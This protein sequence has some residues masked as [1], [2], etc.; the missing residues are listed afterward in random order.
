MR[1]VNM[2]SL[3]DVAYAYLQSR[4]EEQFELARLLIRSRKASVAPIV[5]ALLRIVDDETAVQM[6]LMRLA[7]RSTNARRLADEYFCGVVVDSTARR[8]LRLLHYI[9]PPAG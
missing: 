3:D 8:A 2:G 1:R 7:R 5:G 9:G 4:D 6:E